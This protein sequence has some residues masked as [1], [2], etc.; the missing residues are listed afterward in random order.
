MIISTRVLKIILRSPLSLSLSLSLRS[1]RND[2][3]NEIVGITKIN[4]ATNIII[5]NIIIYCY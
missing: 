3:L 2:I 4:T 1:T 5:M